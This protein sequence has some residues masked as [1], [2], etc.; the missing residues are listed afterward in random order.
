MILADS[1]S[2]TTRMPDLTN[3]RKKLTDYLPQEAEINK[4]IRNMAAKTSRSPA[5]MIQK[6][7]SQ[8][9]HQDIS[10]NS[11]SESPVRDIIKGVIEKPFKLP[12]TKLLN[13]QTDKN[14]IQLPPPNP[15]NKNKISKKL[16]IS[17]LNQEFKKLEPVQLPS[18]KPPLKPPQ[19]SP[20]QR[21]PFIL[22]SPL[23]KKPIRRTSRDELANE[24]RKPRII[25]I[26]QAQQLVLL[27]KT[28]NQ[29]N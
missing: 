22:N 24:T 2:S 18:A 5:T 15:P 29:L 16:K 20:R 21:P 9:Y 14:K 27:Q 8:D 10:E 26:A 6:K 17:P 23:E 11:K 4:R 25:T 7:P 1:G 13:T 19:V 12:K 28:I 3:F